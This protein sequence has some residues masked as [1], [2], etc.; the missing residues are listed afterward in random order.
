M[1]RDRLKDRCTDGR[2]AIHNAYEGLRKSSGWTPFSVRFGSFSRRLTT[3]KT[4]AKD[5]ST[6]TNQCVAMLVSICIIRAYTCT[7]WRRTF[8]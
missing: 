7:V 4:L 3:E 6:N 5:K 2:G 1:T 8:L